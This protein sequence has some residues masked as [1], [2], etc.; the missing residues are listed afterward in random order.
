MRILTRSCD[1]AGGI[2]IRWLPMYSHLHS[3]INFWKQRDN[4]VQDVFLSYSAFAETGYEPAPPD[5]GRALYL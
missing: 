4:R 2:R 5:F 1:L 3:P